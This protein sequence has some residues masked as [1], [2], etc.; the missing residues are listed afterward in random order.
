M[1]TKYWL[2]SKMNNVGFKTLS[3]HELL[4]VM[5]ATDFPEKMNNNTLPDLLSTAVLEGHLRYEKHSNVLYIAMH[6]HILDAAIEDDLYIVYSPSNMGFMHKSM[7]D[8]IYEP[9]PAAELEKL[10]AEQSKADHIEQH[11]MP[12]G[13]CVTAQSAFKSCWSGYTVTNSRG[14]SEWLPKRKFEENYL[15]VGDISGYAP[16]EQRVLIE[17]AELSNRIAKL[18]DFTGTELFMK[19]GDERELLNTQLQHMMNYR[20]ILDQRIDGMSR[21]WNKSR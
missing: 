17:R 13:E 20:H 7:F 6:G 2:N 4:E 19:L 1:N 5:P 15:L 12:V 9:I 16:H 18:A 14:D 21:G 3:C 11:Y 8:S 10:C